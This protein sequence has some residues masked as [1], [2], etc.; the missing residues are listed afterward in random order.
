MRLPFKNLFDKSRLRPGHTGTRLRARR[1]ALPSSLM[2]LVAFS[3]TLLVF[4]VVAYTS[5][6]PGLV[7]ARARAGE[8]GLFPVIAQALFGEDGG[9][10]ADGKKD[11]ADGSS[12]GGVPR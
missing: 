5:S 1:G 12:H 2:G 7:M 9:F 8:E 11:E 4:S 6:L 10:G 3:F